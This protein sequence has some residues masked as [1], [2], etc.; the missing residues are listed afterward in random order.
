MLGRLFPLLAVTVCALT[1]FAEASP[2]NP[3]A[4]LLKRFEHIDTLKAHFIQRTLSD[5]GEE[6][7]KLE[8]EM[9]IRRPLYFKWEVK[10]PYSMTYLLHELN[11]TVVDPDLHQ[12]SY[13]T[14]AS[15]DEVPMVALLL[16]SDMSVLDDFSVV[17]ARNHFK[18]EPLDARQL[19]NSITVYFDG[20]RLDAID[21]RDSQNRLTEFTFKDMEENL[22][23]P[24]ELFSLDIPDDMEVIGERPMDVD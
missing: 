10:K 15:S 24:D 22:T 9:L 2:T 11:L 17:Q 4:A 13:Q 7:Q 6:L 16:H 14:L 21:V 23:I 12:V 3:G 19:F 5:N 8:G 1:G 18:L 20:T